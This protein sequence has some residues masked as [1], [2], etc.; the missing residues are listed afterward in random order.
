MEQGESERTI[1][2]QCQQQGLPLPAKIANAPELALGLEFI[3]T[4]FWELSTCRP[5]G[6]GMGAIPWSAIYDYAAVHGLDADETEDLA[7]FVRKLD[8]KFL[9]H[10]APKDKTTPKGSKKLKSKK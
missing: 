4:A 1:I 2:K 5:I 10:H 8:E 6:M 7:Y 3:Y 9:K